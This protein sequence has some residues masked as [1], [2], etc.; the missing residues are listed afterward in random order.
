MTNKEKYQQAFSVLKASRPIEVEDLVM[1]KNKTIK[2]VAAVAAA[3]VLC[4]VAS[5]SICYA[6]TGATWVEK[7]VVYFNGEPVEKPVKVTTT[8]NGLYEYT[9]DVPEGSA[10][11]MIVT[12]EKYEDTQIM[13]EQEADVEI[14]AYI[15]EVDGVQWFCHK[16]ERVD[17]TEDFADGLAEGT[18]TVDGQEYVYQLTGHID[19]YYVSIELAK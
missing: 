10:G 7:M 3:F 11:M 2:S 15:E 6:T 14:T 19:G 9:I 13:V 5:N 12:D 1:N 8:G 17:I 16:G 4:F 18:I